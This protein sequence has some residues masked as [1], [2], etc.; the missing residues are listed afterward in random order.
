MTSRV[1]VLEINARR[2]QWADREFM[3]WLMTK[4]DPD[5]SNAPVFMTMSASEAGAEG[6]RHVAKER[7]GIVLPHMVSVEMF[8]VGMALAASNGV[9]PEETLDAMF[10]SYLR[11]C[12][13]AKA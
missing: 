1:N 6:L 4:V 3:H 8:G 11:T 10:R 13:G 9:P 7:L 5:A 2:P 12:G